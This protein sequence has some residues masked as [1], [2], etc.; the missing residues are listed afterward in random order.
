VVVG[1]EEKDGHRCYRVELRAR[2]RDVDH[3]DGTVWI[4]VENPGPVRVVGAVSDPPFP[5]SQILLDKAFE[6]GPGGLWLVSRHRG[7]V[8][9]G[10][11]FMR[12]RGERTILYEDY[13]VGLAAIPGCSSEAGG[14]TGEPTAPH[15]DQGSFSH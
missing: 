5:A 15:S 14:D 12:K 4:D 6:P 3:I 9:V 1:I 13:E 8:E 7:E 10:L 11:L 2:V